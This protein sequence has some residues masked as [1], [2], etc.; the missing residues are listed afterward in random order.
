MLVLIMDG[1]IG[2]ILRVDLT[3]SEYSIQNFDLEFARKWIGGRGF[4]IKILFDE[5]PAGADPLGEDNKIVVAPGPL[6]GYTLPNSGKVVVASKSPL[7]NGYGDGNLG[8]HLAKQ[9]RK[10]GFDAIVISGKAKK[11]V[12]LIIKDDVITFQKASNYWGKGTFEINE[13]LEKEHGRNAGILSIGPAGEN[14]V[15]IAVVRSLYGRAGGRPGI[16]A[17][18]GSK[19]L[20]AIVAV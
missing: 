15:K 6:S 11:P 1:W 16:G 5:I 19:N 20:K 17:V 14:C 3:K 18:F 13:L 10:A 7:T 4:A 12:I 8:T 2:K 9:L